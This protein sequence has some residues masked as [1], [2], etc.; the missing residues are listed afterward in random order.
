MPCMG[1]AWGLAGVGELGRLAARVAAIPLS[2]ERPLDAVAF[3]VFAEG[4]GVEG[5]VEER[6]GARQG[7]PKRDR[8]RALYRIRSI[9]DVA[10]TSLGL[11]GR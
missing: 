8:W 5:G 10:V 11:W 3:D 9:G 7:P 6:S 4:G 1:F 2:K